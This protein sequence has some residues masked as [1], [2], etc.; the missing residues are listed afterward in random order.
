MSGANTEM[1][2]TIED[3]TLGG[4]LSKSANKPPYHNAAWRVGFFVGQRGGQYAVPP[5]FVA[6]RAQWRLGFICGARARGEMLRR[7]RAAA[8]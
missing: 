2:S 1:R 7:E 4:R 8:S 3:R 6:D 5:F